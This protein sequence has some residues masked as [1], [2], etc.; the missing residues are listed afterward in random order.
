MKFE[1]DTFSIGRIKDNDRTIACLLNWDD[2]PQSFSLR[3][4]SPARVV[5]FWEDTDL[6]THKKTYEAR[7]LP[8]R[9]AKLLV[10]TS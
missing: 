8:S 6:G 5:D 4:D 10:L 2:R 1:D 3:L 9:S 7:N